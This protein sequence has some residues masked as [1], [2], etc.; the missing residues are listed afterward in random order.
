MTDE[1]DETNRDDDDQLGGGGPKDLATGGELSDAPGGSG[2]DIGVGTGAGGDTGAGQR[3]GRLAVA[4][5]EHRPLRLE[6]AE[7]RTSGRHHQPRHLGGRI[8]GGVQ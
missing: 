3:L 1:R 4:Q 6:P 2:P 8:D 7:Q 5:H